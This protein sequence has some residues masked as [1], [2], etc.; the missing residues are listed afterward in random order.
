[1][2]TVAVLLSGCG[3]LDG[4]E[5]RE[6]VLTLLAL[7]S[8]DVQYKIFA[9]D[10]DQH[11]VVNHLTNEP[12]KA[13]RNILVESARIARGDVQDISHLEVGNFDALIIPGGFGVAKNLCTFAFEAAPLMLTKPLPPK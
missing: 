7:D 5:I 6:S 10:K 3:Y 1:M 4:A 2:K 13:S 9:P 11:H 8:E 12:S